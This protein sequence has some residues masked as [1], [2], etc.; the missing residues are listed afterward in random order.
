MQ[1]SFSKTN[2]FTLLPDTLTKFAHQRFQQSN[3]FFSF[4]H[5]AIS[6]P[7]SNMFVPKTENKPQLISTGIL[8]E[9]E[10]RINQ[11]GK[12]DWQDSQ[13]GV[14]PVDLL[15]DNPWQ[16]FFRFYPEVWIDLAY[17]RDLQ[18]ETL[19]DG[20]ADS[21][22]RRILAPLKQGLSVFASVPSDQIKVLDVGCGM[23]QTLK[24]IR[25]TLPEASLFGVDLSIVGL[26]KT[27]QLFSEN[28]GELP[29]LTHANAED[30]PYPDNYFHGVSNVFLFHELPAH[31]RQR[32]IKECFRVT[33]PG[34][35]LT[36]CDS[37]QL[38]DFPEFEVLM[39][40]YFPT[41]FHESYHRDYIQDNLVEHLEKAGFEKIETEN[42]FFSKYWIARKPE[43][44]SNKLLLR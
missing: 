5:K 42:H 39:K 26:Q 19:F 10:Q 23:G 38:F 7:L 2:Q 29:Q 15:F 18:V 24:F 40:N 17:L 13:K 6:H 4:V 8:L 35:I 12:T 33:K 37:M 44:A 32:V 25:A 9:I 11:L 28:S 21:M 36:I 43:V 31:A 16:N 27:K 14:Y 1:S 20:V 22:R 30:L 34:G 41:M 3:S